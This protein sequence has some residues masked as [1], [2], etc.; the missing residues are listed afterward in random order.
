KRK[1]RVFIDW[2][3]NQRGQTSVAP[4]S[5]RARRGAPVATP[6]A[7]DELADAKSGADYD[8]KSLPRRLAA[9][10][11]DPWARYGAAAEILSEGAISWAAKA[12]G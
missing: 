1:G 2:L 11:S 8:V 9:Q 4:F 12:G 3:R 7:W 6:I 10:K 5:V